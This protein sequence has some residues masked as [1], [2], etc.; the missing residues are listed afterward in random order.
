MLHMRCYHRPLLH[1]TINNRSSPPT[2]RSNQAKLIMQM[3]FC[4]PTQ[5]AQVQQS[6]RKGNGC[7]RSVD[8]LFSMLKLVNGQLLLFL[9]CRCCRH[10]DISGKRESFRRDRIFVFIT[11]KCLLFYKANNWDWESFY[12]YFGIAHARHTIS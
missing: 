2:V 8:R 9:S 5:S 3:K 7:F 6:P 4:R 10:F 12:L 11:D 1:H